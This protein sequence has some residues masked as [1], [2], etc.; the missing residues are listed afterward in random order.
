MFRLVN[1]VAGDAAH[2]AARL[3]EL[4]LHHEQQHQELL[5][6]DI[7]HVLWT[8][9]LRPTYRTATTKPD[10]KSR[11][12][13][14]RDFDGGVRAIG[15]ED[16]GFAF[17]NEGPRHRVF[18]EPYRLASRLLTNGEYLAFIE[19]GGY[20]RS[21]LWLSAGLAAARDRHWEAPLYWE[22]DA[23]GRWTEFTLGGTRVLH[24]AALSDPV[25]HVSFYE[26]DAYARWAGCRLPTEFEW[27]AASRG[28]PVE[29]SFVESEAFHPRPDGGSGAALE[30]L[31]GDAWQW[32]QSAYVGYPNFR[33]AP[34]AVGEYNG[35]WMADQWVLRGASCATPRS[36]ARPS[37]RNFFPSDARW[38]FAGIRLAD[39]AA[40][41]EAR[42]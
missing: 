14:W 6:T 7:K 16:E 23:D 17:D 19:E 31:Y 15:Y 5:L 22:R 10:T 34:G 26:A 36:H 2:P 18:L 25:V 9:P 24:G 3:V 40:G 1:R 28:Q 30:Q 29:G 12:I 41:A 35:K 27:E 13:E 38:Q 32:T 33:P 4:G 21:E 20:R 42:L 11:P 37:Y 8:N 39:R